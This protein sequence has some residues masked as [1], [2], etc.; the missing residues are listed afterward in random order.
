MYPKFHPFIVRLLKHKVIRRAPTLLEVNESKEL[1]FLSGDLD[2][3]LDDGFAGFVH[4]VK[5][6]LV[7][8]CCQY[9]M[10]DHEI[11]FPLD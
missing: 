3:R 7:L 2:L 6:G 8:I 10:L 9:T 4:V 11:I 1:E 5:I